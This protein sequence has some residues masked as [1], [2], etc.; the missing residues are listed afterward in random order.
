MTPLKVK[1][2]YLSDATRRNRSGRRIYSGNPFSYNA[3]LDDLEP[4]YVTVCVDVYG[5]VSEEHYQ[6]IRDN[7]I[8]LIGSDVYSVLMEGLITT[9][10]FTFGPI[11]DKSVCGYD[12]YTKLMNSI[13]NNG[14]ILVNAHSSDKYISEWCKMFI[15]LLET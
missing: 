14:M 15:N 8:P 11:F 5:S 7:D 12:V 2:I 6:Y 1:S 10:K 4:L 3:L 9:L 13:S